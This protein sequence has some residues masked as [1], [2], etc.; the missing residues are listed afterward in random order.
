MD[1]DPA[2]PAT[3]RRGL[4]GALGAAGLAGAAA[5]SIARPASAAP[6][7]PTE[8]DKELLRAAMEL[9]LTAEALYR[10]AIG[11]GLSGVAGELAAVFAENHVSSGAE[12]A[13][14]SGFS[15]DTRNEQVFEQL[16]P[17][18]ATTNAEA[19]AEAAAGL[20]NTAVATHTELL[21]GYESVNARKL[22]ASIIVVE[23]RMATVL[24]DLGGF[25]A[26]LDDVF[27]PAADALEAAAGATS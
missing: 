21:A 5:L 14:A 6:T 20:E 10:E 1:L 16:Q 22:T 7:S 2:A 17:A 11:A 24:T 27:E 8:A 12:I 15:A 23:A 18:F 9:E 26:S 13:G 25:A 19:F 3:S 4:L